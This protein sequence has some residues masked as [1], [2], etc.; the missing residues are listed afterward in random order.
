MTTRYDDWHNDDIARRHRIEV[1]PF[2]SGTCE[3]REHETCRMY[4]CECR[5]HQDAA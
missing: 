4:G 5:C 3:L 1:T 2:I